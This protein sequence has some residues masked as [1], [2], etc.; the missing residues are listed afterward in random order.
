MWIICLAEMPCHIFSEKKKK[1]KKYKKNTKKKKSKCHLLQLWL[2]LLSKTDTKFF[3]YLLNVAKIHLM[4]KFL[5]LSHYVCQDLFTT[6][7]CCQ[8]FA[9]DLCVPNLELIYC[10]KQP[11][12]MICP[13]SD[14]PFKVMT[15]PHRVNY[16]IWDNLPTNFIFVENGRNVIIH[17]IQ[18]IEILDNAPFPSMICK[19]HFNV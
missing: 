8:K 11:I 16:Y 19:M 3:L 13:Y 5:K 18:C 4:E 9:K 10:Y 1:K 7:L 6:F 2:A 15:L 14:W 12:Y 17:P